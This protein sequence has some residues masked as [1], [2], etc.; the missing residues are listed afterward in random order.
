MSLPKE[1]PPCKRHAVDCDAGAA[2]KT[3]RTEPKDMTPDDGHDMTTSD[4]II[5]DDIVL[6]SSQRCLSCRRWLFLDAPAMSDMRCSECR[7]K[8]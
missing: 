8:R 4:S 2:F 6:P 3:Q 7:V 1:F 5:P